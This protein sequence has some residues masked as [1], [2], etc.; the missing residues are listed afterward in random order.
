M[1]IAASI[2]AKYGNVSAPVIAQ[3]LEKNAATGRSADWERRR[4]QQR[5]RDLEAEVARFR[6]SLSQYSRTAHRRA[7]S[8]RKIEPAAPG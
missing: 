8:P 3:L 4:L 5:I 7:I 1:R 2:R 6:R